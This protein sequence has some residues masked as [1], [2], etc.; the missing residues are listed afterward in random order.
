MVPSDFSICER[1]CECFISIN[2]NTFTNVRVCIECHGTGGTRGNVNH[3]DH[4]KFI[5]CQHSRE[6][7]SVGIIMFSGYFN[8][9]LIKNKLNEVF[10]MERKKLLAEIERRKVAMVIFLKTKMFLPNLLKN[11]YTSSSNL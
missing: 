3:M 6:Y 1:N 5:R 4:C 2:T 10:V 8:T 9:I 7:A 11:K